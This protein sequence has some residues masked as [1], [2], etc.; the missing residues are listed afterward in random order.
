MQVCPHTYI[1]FNIL[2]ILAEDA[3]TRKEDQ[4]VMKKVLIK[5]FGNKKHHC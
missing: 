1:F 3:V 4:D 5:A 2:R